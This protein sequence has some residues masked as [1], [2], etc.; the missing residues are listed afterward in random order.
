MYSLIKGDQIK[1]MKWANHVAR[2]D[3]MC[4]SFQLKNQSVHD[5]VILKWVL[6]KLD[7]RVC[8]GTG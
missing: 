3:E 4:I 1:G 7:V 6:K 5:S 2:M 8:K